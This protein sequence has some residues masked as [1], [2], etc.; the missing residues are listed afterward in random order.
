VSINNLKRSKDETDAF[1]D[2]FRDAFARDFGDFDR[3]N[4]RIRFIGKVDML[5]KDIVKSM[6]SIEERTKQNSGL[7]VWIAMPYSGQEEV[8]DAV[9][10]VL[11]NIDLQKD[12]Q[13]FSKDDFEKYL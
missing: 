6:M 2:I 10:S 5:D 12:S 13:S 11:K 8:I 4:I 9:K 3:L 7:N 1:M